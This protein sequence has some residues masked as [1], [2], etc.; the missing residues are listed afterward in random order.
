MTSGDYYDQQSGGGVWC[1]DESCIVTNCIIVD[2][3]AWKDAAGVFRGTLYNC[4]LLRNY[5]AG[6]GGGVS[7]GALQAC[8]VRD[9]FSFQ[10]GGVYYSVLRNCVVVSNLAYRGGGAEGGELYH[11]TIVTNWAMQS[12]GGVYDGRVVNCLVYYND[13]TNNPNW[14]FGTIRYTCTDPL[15]LGEGNI[16]EAPVFISIAAGDY[17]LTV[18]SAGIDAATNGLE[19]VDKNNVPRPLDGNLDGTN[20]ADMGAYEFVHGAGDSDQ[21]GMLDGYEIDYRLNP[22]D[23]ADAALDSDLDGPVNSSEFIAGT[24]PNDSNS[25]LRLTG[26]QRS[27]TNEVVTWSSATGRVYVLERMGSMTGDTWSVAASGLVARPPQNVYT[28]VVSQVE[29]YYRV[30]VYRTNAY[31][32]P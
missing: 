6:K 24:N 28:D 29:S 13:C 11:C 14:E 3:N 8:D 26:V 2:N 22:L 9:N 27:S 4:A 16:M 23:A 5:S 19:F 31:Y 17:R 25:F 32:P 7:E 30:W 12:A 10:G 18:G 1:S 20:T 21:D 15:P